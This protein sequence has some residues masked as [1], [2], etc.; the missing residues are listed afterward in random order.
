[1][2][3]YY[4]FLKRLWLKNQTILSSI[5]SI[6]IYIYRQTH[7]HT[8]LLLLIS[9]LWHRQAI[10]E[11]KG[12]E[13]S[14]SAECRIRT[15]RVSETQSPADWMP[16]DKPTELS[17]IKLKHTH[18]RVLCPKSSFM[19]MH[20]VFDQKYGCSITT[21]RLLYNC[22]YNI[23]SY[24]RVYKIFSY[25]KWPPE[26][27]SLG[28]SALV[29]AVRSH[30][31]FVNIIV[32]IMVDLATVLYMARLMSCHDMCQICYLIWPLFSS[33][34]IFYKIYCRILFKISIKQNCS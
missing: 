8:Y 22:S 18:T 31:G 16:A 7:T 24:I 19:L 10:F 32:I 29:K 4:Y 20:N 5:F 14:S 1:M 12:D 15:Q 25:L 30:K 21:V 13:L 26:I 9:M 6:Y 33:N 2:S 17:R 34:N 27:K 3:A 11:S 23:Q 28:L